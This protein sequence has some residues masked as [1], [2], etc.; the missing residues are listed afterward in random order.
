[1]ILT[2]STRGQ[3][4]DT[5]YVHQS[6]GSWYSLCPL[7]RRQL[8]VIVSTRVQVVDTYYV[9]QRAGGWYL[10]CPL[11]RRQLIVIVSTRVQ[12][13]DTYCVHWRI[14]SSL[15]SWL[16]MQDELLCLGVSIIE[17]MLH[18]PSAPA[19]NCHQ[20]LAIYVFTMKLQHDIY[21]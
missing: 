1:M 21:I 3:A 16:L 18:Q 8:I 11:E 17:V 6:A 13:V 4:V 19:T 2:V 9:H 14:G 12:A 15:Y 7:E 20:T 10:L 5:Y